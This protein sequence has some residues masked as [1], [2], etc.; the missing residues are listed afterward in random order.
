MVTDEERDGVSGT[1][2]NPEP[3]LGVGKSSTTGAGGRELAASAARNRRPLLLAAGIDL[4]AGGLMGW[5]VG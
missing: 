3:A 2:I 1:E 5:E 4:Y